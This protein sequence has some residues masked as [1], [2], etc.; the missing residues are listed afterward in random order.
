MA[1]HCD[2]LHSTKGVYLPLDEWPDPDG[3]TL[4][5][6]EYERDVLRQYPNVLANRPYR[7]RE[8]RRLEKIA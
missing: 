6:E 4:T 1:W 3:R 5:R 8:G 7:I 2:V